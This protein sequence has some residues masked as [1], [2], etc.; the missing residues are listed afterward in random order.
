MLNENGIIS[1]PAGISGM[2]NLCLF[3]VNTGTIPAIPLEI[4]S[5]TRLQHLRL[6]NHKISE[7]P[8]ELTQLRSLCSLSL[9]HNVIT[10]FP[11]FLSS[12]TSLVS[13][14]LESNLITE[15][16]YLGYS[17]FSH[18]RKLF[19]NDNQITRVGRLNGLRNLE[20]LRLHYNKLD[21]ESLSGFSF[22][23]LQ[24]LSAITLSGN[25]GITELPDS[26]APILGG[27]LLKIALDPAIAAYYDV[28]IAQPVSQ[29]TRAQYQYYW[30]YQPPNLHLS[31][32]DRLSLQSQ[33]ARQGVL[34]CCLTLRKM[35]LG[36]D[37][38]TARGHYMTTKCDAESLESRPVRYYLP[39]DI[40][41]FLIQLIFEV[42]GVT[43]RYKDH[44]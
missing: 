3:S 10:T 35:L 38:V 27:R 13:L 44:G 43:F 21:T 18:L 24:Y 37:F 32:E 36:L 41:L 16:P 5:L 7:I 25:P 22:E 29:Q 42:F 12:L 23:P 26:I 19:L 39:R 34:R 9:E 15:T 2:T 30:Q 8:L 6:S 33:L 11:C 4:C 40:E 28:T 17:A 1:I 20:E 14:Y 31:R